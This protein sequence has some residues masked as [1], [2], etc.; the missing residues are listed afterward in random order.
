MSDLSLDTKKALLENKQKREAAAK[1][2]EPQTLVDQTIEQIG[3]A[4]KSTAADKPDPSTESVTAG[5]EK[6]ISAT[7]PDPKETPTN[8]TTESTPVA[9]TEDE[10]KWD[11]GIVETP[12]SSVGPDIKKL[13]SAWSLEVNSE[14][15]L[16]KT[17]SER[18]TKLKE[19]EV[20]STKVFENVPAELVEAVEVAKKGGDWASF[21]GSSLLNVAALDPVDLF[22]E[23][24]E[25]T[26][27][28]RYKL[29]DGSIDYE[30]FDEALQAIPVAMKHMQGEQLKQRLA[31]NQAQRKA[32]AQAQVQAQQEQFS[33]NLAE[34]SKTLTTQFPK[35]TFGIT[36]EPKHVSTL[37]EGIT[38]GKLIKKHLGD[39][40]AEILA[41]F[42]ASKL[43]STIAKAEWTEGI[44]KF[45]KAQGITEGKKS[46]LNK[47]QNP[48]IT[49][50]GISAAPETTQDE[51]PLTHT[52]KIKAFVERTRPAAG[53]L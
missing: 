29:P 51:K 22:E 45:N 10:P 44:A 43:M 50:S 30:K 7:D 38:S 1:A 47:V 36:V 31:Y 8:T 26:Q 46:I 41:K 25:R 15:E 12:A 32:Q 28:H 14:D 11:A 52:E 3:V 17:V 53:S 35:E 21:V 6:V 48:Q 19:L 40:P 9:Q 23:E 5:E 4:P 24:F 18:L 39:V 16:V 37:Y 34:S 20:Q 13:G 27:I 49:G 2:A 42:D 33:K